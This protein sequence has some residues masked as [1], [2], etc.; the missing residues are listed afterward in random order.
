MEP[1]SWWWRYYLYILGFLM[2]CWD[3]SEWWDCEWNLLK[4][5][6]FFTA[7][8]R[9]PDDLLSIEMFDDD[10]AFMHKT[11]EFMTPIGHLPPTTTTTS[12]NNNGHWRDTNWMVEHG[13]LGAS[14][15]KLYRYQRLL[16]THPLPTSSNAPLLMTFFQYHFLHKLATCHK[17]FAW[18]MQF[19]GAVIIPGTHHK[20]LD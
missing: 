1:S 5:V 17:P 9:F 18:E 14:K 4:S 8:I 13:V 10:K 11:K 2:I 16:D 3:G 15:A 19:T 6:T 7:N 20:I 12:L